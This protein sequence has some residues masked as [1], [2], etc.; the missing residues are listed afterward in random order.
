MVVV[1]PGDE[2]ALR[3]GAQG[4]AVQKPQGA[5]GCADDHHRLFGGLHGEGDLGGGLLVQEVVLGGALA[6]VRGPPLQKAGDAPGDRQ[7]QIAAA[8]LLPGL[9]TARGRLARGTAGGG[10][11]PLEPVEAVPGRLLQG[12]A[13]P[14]EGQQGRNRS[15][16]SRRMISSIGRSSIS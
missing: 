9:D 4:E 7:L 8:V 14:Q 6:S 1:D 12:P 10:E 15:G 11:L 5:P 16:V 3:A 2:P 13:L